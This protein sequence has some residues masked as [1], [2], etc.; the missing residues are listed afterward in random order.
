MLLCVLAIILP[1]GM[2]V[3]TKRNNPSSLIHQKPGT[4]TVAYIGVILVTLCGVL[5]N[6]PMSEDCLSAAVIMASVIEVIS[7][8]EEF[9]DKL[10]DKKTK[11]SN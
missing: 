11:E 4:K 9:L 1:T 7:N 5:W 6:E 10:K 3:W 2:Y 8:G